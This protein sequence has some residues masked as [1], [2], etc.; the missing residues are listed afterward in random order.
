[1]RFR[2]SNKRKERVNPH[3]KHKHSFLIICLLCL[4]VAFFADMHG[5]LRAAE[6]EESSRTVLPAEEGESVSESEDAVLAGADVEIIEDIK[7][8]TRELNDYRGKTAERQ[9][10]ILDEIESLQSEISSLEKAVREHSTKKERLGKEIS[11]LEKE[12]GHSEKTI[13]Y[14]GDRLSEFRRNLGADIS[15]ALQQKIEPQL[16]EMDEKLAHHDNSERAGALAALSGSGVLNFIFERDNGVWFHGQ[17]VTGSGEVIDGKHALIGPLSFFVS[18]DRQT[19]GI[20]RQ[21]TGSVHPFVWQRLSRQ[22]REAIVKLAEEGKGRVPVDVAGGKAMELREHD[23]GLMA[24]LKQGRFVMIPLL[25]LAGVCAVFAVYKFS[26]LSRVTNRVAETRINEILAAVSQDEI[27]RALT[28]CGRL[29]RPLRDV[30]REGIQCRGS[31][32]EHIEELMYEKLMAQTPSLERFLAP[33]AVCASAAPLLGL[34]GTVTGMIHTFRLITVF[35]TG[36][37]QTLSSGISEALVTTETG[38]IIAIPA[39][40]IH[41]YLSRR[42]RRSIALTQQAATMFLNGLKLRGE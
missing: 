38:L 25:V 7:Q 6:D 5:H 20:T 24:H 22:E 15:A 34:L 11:G 31:S 30:L 27:D 37:A 4:A 36:D 10:E 28:L 8:T 9:N 13:E 12:I 35:G 1:M 21:E 29:R 42:V 32:K 40:L 2:Y 33:L 14:I 26:Q 19:A 17:A 41:A 16:Q 3:P 18:E 23:S 39:L